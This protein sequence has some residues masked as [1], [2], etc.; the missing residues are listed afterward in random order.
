LLL[1]S[2]ILLLLADPHL[3]ATS[4]PPSSR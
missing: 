2:V 1:K 3:D 4:A